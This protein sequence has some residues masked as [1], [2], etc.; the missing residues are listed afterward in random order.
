M[1]EDNTGQGGERV[2]GITVHSSPTGSSDRRN[3]RRTKGEGRQRHRRAQGLEVGALERRRVKSLRE[4]RGQK[5]A[6]SGTM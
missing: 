6:E 2:A 3:M 4:G 5:P 1:E